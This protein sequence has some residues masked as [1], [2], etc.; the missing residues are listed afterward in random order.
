MWLMQFMSNYHG[1]RFKHGS[2]SHFSQNRSTDLQFPQHPLSPC[3]S[4]AATRHFW[5]PLEFSRCRLLSSSSRV[6][7]LS[8]AVA[9][10]SRSAA[11]CHFWS[12]LAFSRRP[13][14]LVSSRVQPLPPAPCRCLPATATSPA[15]SRSVAFNTKVF[16]PNINSNGSICLDILK[17]QW[18][19]ALTIS[20]VLLNLMFLTNLLRTNAYHLVI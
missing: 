3:R 7:P 15:P 18:S 10:L 9:S 2:S 5:F 6:Q 16:H 19:P 14:F 17:D 12:P 20:K 1:V 13:P 4:V 8:P 11:A